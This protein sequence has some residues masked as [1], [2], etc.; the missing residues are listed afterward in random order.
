M[1]TNDRLVKGLL[2]GKKRESTMGREGEKRGGGRATA[3]AM[4]CL[5]V[6][7]NRGRL[8]LFYENIVVTWA[9]G[10]CVNRWINPVEEC[11]PSVSGARWG[12]KMSGVSSE[13]RGCF[14]LYS[15]ACAECTHKAL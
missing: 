14:Y 1:K 5:H 7:M 9:A 12:M 2:N 15:P 4:R 10:L 3:C 13:P 11:A 6:K 8:V